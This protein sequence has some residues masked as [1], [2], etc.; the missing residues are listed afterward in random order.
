MLRR[1]WTTTRVLLVGTGAYAGA[2]VADLDQRGATEKSLAVLR[3]YL[4]A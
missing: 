2:V 3:P 1:D 4:R